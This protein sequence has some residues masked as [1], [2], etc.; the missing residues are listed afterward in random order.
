MARPELI[1][2]G[3]SAG[4]LRPLQTIVRSLPAEFPVCVLAVMHVSSESTLAHILSRGAHVSVKEGETGDP[5]KPGRFYVA[6]PDQHMLVR[7]GVIELNRGPR[8]NRARPAIDPLFRSAAVA[9]QERV[10]GVVLT[11]FLEDGA[12]GLLAIKRAGGVAV[13]QDPQDAE[14]PAMPNSAL[15]RVSVDYCTTLRELPELLAFL[16][17]ADRS[18]HVRHAVPQSAAQETTDAGEP[19]PRW[20]L[21][22]ALE[23][24]MLEKPV[25]HE[26]LTSELGPP[27][28]MACPECGG[29]LW[30]VHDEHVRR[31]RC[32]MGHGLTASMALVGQERVVE[33]SLWVAAR[34]LEERASLLAIMAAD[35]RAAGRVDRVRDYAERE[36]RSRQNAAALRKLL[37]QTDFAPVPVLSRGL[38]D[39]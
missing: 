1:V 22:P 31:Y 23:L 28:A 25:S 7:D 5:I 39:S 4:G 2:I 20:P 9:Y 37:S 11:G 6:P 34:A 24:G 21:E 32:L 16:A 38:K 13:V 12:A 3:A 15:A 27:V 10:I 30:E 29:P 17:A 36:L 8:E 19:K 33:H 26:T 14:F 35:E 18:E